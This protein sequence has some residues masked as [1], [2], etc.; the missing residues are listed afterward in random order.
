MANT[1]TVDSGGV[2]TIV[3]DGLSDV[4]FADYFPNGFRLQAVGFIGGAT[5]KL[6]MRLGDVDG[7]QLFPVG[8]ADEDGY[9]ETGLM[10]RKLYMKAADCTFVTPAS[11]L[12]TVYF[13]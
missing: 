4:D 10:K 7:V 9:A 2:I 5:D 8:L 3:P 1:V 12:I 6:Y 13:N 11:C